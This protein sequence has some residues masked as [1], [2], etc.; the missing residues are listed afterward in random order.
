MVLSCFLRKSDGIFA[1][2]VKC[3]W[4]VKA[5]S[6]ARRGSRKRRLDDFLLARDSARSS[7]AADPACSRHYSKESLAVK[8]SHR[9]HYQER[10]AP[11]D[12]PRHMVNEVKGTRFTR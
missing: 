8:T 7:F 9:S 2:H 5:T 12:S 1:V 11:L 3:R 6:T 4:G 10:S